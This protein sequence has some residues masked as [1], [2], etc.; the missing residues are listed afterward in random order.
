MG[1]R[2]QR[3]WQWS[4]VVRRRS[5][6]RMGEVTALAPSLRK[7]RDIAVDVRHWTW[8]ESAQWPPIELVTKTPFWSDPEYTAVRQRLLRPAPVVD[9]VSGGAFVTLQPMGGAP[10][11]TGEPPAHG[12]EEA[13]HA[14]GPVCSTSCPR[15]CFVGCPG[16]GGS[17]GRARAREREDGC[18]CW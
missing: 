11:G 12:E 15:P 9:I 17:D 5:P 14:G 16:K 13:E 1:G 18:V 6:E 4:V 8:T 3:E 7:A 2:V 10:F